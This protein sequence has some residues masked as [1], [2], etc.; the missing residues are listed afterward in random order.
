MRWKWKDCEFRCVY[1]VGEGSGSVSGLRETGRASYLGLGEEKWR[2][3]LY[4]GSWASYGVLL[5][6]VVWL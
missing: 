6:S 2:W 5:C 3:A 1:C 4:V